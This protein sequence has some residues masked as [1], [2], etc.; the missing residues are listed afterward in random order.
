MGTRRFTLSG[1][2]RIKRARGLKIL[3]NGLSVG[4]GKRRSDSPE[5]SLRKTENI[6]MKHASF[7]KP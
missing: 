1:S 7:L 2:K 3:A 4:P 6:S 5:V